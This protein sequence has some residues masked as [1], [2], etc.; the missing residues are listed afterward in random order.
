MEKII[1]ANEDT[2]FRRT[3]NR[4]S[5]MKNDGTISSANFIGP[6]TSVNIERLTTVEQTFAG[7]ENF[8][9]VR[10]I[11]GNI[12]KLGEDVLHD[13]IERNYA[14]AI[15]PGKRSASVARKL[16]QIA[17]IVIIPSL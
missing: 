14:H 4:P 8:G 16:A 17:N 3:P 15:I 11:T 7:Y 10:L 12:R 9:L 13:P 6:N 1:V 2:V 5:H